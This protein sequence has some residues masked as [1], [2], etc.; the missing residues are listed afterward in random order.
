[1]YVTKVN[2]IHKQTKTKKKQW[3]DVDADF[4]GQSKIAKAKGLL[5]VVVMKP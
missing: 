3:E 4:M 1:M 2:L 5:Y